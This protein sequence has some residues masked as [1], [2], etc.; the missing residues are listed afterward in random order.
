MEKALTEAANRKQS[1]IGVEL[2]R[3][4]TELLKWSYS[5]NN[6]NVTMWSGQLL[7]WDPVLGVAT[8]QGSALGLLLLSDIC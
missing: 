7:N 1:Q 8:P 5:E 3:F 2:K 6:L 4:T